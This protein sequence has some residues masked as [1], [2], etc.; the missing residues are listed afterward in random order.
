MAKQNQLV[1]DLG[2]VNLTDKE[3][4]ALQKAIHKTVTKKIQK[5]SVTTTQATNTTPPA[6]VA[7]NLT[8]TGKTAELEIAFSDVKPGLSGLTA[9]LND[10][11]PQSVNQSGTIRFTGVKKNDMIDID[12]FGAGSKTITIS[13]V[14]ASPMQMNFAPGQHISGSFLILG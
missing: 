3:L 9:I 12:G 7:N 11:A 14:T 1:I 10:G 13:G 4:K 6:A 5:A 8:D 2:N